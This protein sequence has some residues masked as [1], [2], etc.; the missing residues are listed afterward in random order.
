MLPVPDQLA[1]PVELF[2]PVKWDAVKRPILIDK[3]KPEMVLCREDQLFE[4][5]LDDAL[6]HPVVVTDNKLGLGKPLIPA[7]LCI[8]LLRLVCF[9]FEARLGVRYFLENSLNRRISVL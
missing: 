4:G 8:N 2:D 7:D 3:L 5:D 1:I 6:L 9:P